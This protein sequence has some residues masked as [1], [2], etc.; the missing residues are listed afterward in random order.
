MW[1]SRNKSWEGGNFKINCQIATESTSICIFCCFFL[2]PRLLIVVSVAEALP[3]LLLDPVAYDTFGWFQE[4]RLLI[5]TPPAK[6]DRE[7]ERERR[8]RG[9]GTWNFEYW[10]QVWAISVPL[11]PPHTPLARGQGIPTVKIAVLSLLIKTKRKR[12]K[13]LASEELSARSSLS[14]AEASGS[15]LNWNH[16]KLKMFSWVEI[17]ALPRADVFSGE[18]QKRSSSSKYNF[19]HKKKNK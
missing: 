17:C 19:K 3:L 4:M 2:L 13:L 14:S 12:Q 1:I 10:Q 11:P 9:A 16:S 8:G 5:R 15:K 6:P 18:K 7:R